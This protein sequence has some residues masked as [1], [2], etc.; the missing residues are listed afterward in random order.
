[1]PTP[2]EAR[3]ALVVVTDRAVVDARRLIGR[4]ADRTR[5][6][7]VDG[8]P[9]VVAYYSNGTAALAADHYDDIRAEADAPGLYVAEPVVDLDEQRLRRHALWAAAPM[10]GEQPDLEL[11]SSRVAEVVQYET[12]RPFRETITTNTRRDPAAVG[13]RRIA[14]VGCKFCRMLADR[15]AVYRA[16]TA[17]FAAHPHCGC[18]AAPVFDGNAGPE[19]SVIQYV[20]SQ[21]RRTPAQQA[22]LRRYL[23]A[24]P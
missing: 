12:A 19:A 17:T 20:A 15:G 9:T 10:Y 2:D 1:V 11:V 3:R 5:D 4:N 8:I 21:R 7:L 13:W 16:S 23:A 18:S 24:M 14:S 6:A 22:A